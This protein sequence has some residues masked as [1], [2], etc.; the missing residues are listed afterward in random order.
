MRHESR[1]EL[2]TPEIL[3]IKITE[4]SDARH[5]DSYTVTQNAMI[6]NKRMH[7]RRPQGNEKDGKNKSTKNERFKFQCHRCRKFGHKAVDCRS[8]DE[9]HQPSA[10]KWE[11][12]SLYASEESSIQSAVLR[13]GVNDSLE[14]WCLDSGATSHFCKE[15]NSLAEIFDSGHTQLNLANNASTEIK[16]RGMAIFS[17]DV[18]EK[19][20]NIR[21]KIPCMYLIYVQI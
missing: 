5:N 20:N 21:L 17:T 10:K 16:A 2:P 9:N 13:A 15:F 18:L 4:E 14:M 7:K 8:K 11:D 6:E 1:D 12:V 3:R 19:Q